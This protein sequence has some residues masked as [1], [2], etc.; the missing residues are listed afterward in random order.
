M[1]VD[2]GY[3][4][5]KKTD[6]PEKINDYFSTGEFSCQCKL[7]SCVDQKISVDLIDRL[8][9]LRVAKKSPMTITSGFRCTAHQEEIRNSGVSTVVAKV[10][11]HELGNAADVKF[12]ALRI[13]E[14]MN[15]A[16]TK[17]SYIGIATNFLHLD[18]RPAKVKGEWVT[19]KY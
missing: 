6:K 5:W 16:K 7:P 17:F 3:Y 2:N 12:K 18:V 8:T 4:V 11:Q 19:W 10:S 1:K 14:W 15:D 13:D 9:Y